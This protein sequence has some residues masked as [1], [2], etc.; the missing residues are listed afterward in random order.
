MKE[1]AKQI[2]VSPATVSLALQEDSRVALKTRERVKELAEKLNY[3]PNR[4]G[5]S[6][7]I[8]RS[9]T[10]GCFISSVTDSFYGEIVDGIGEIASDNGYGLLM[11]MT[12]TPGEISAQ[13]ARFF[14]EKQVDG[15]IVAGHYSKSS[16]ILLDFEEAGIPVVMCSDRSFSDVIPFVITDDYKGGA[17]IA[18]YLLGLGHKRLAYC[19]GVSE[20]DLRYSGAKY[21]MERYRQEVPDFCKTEED[22]IELM[23]S[24]KAP[25]GII[26]YSDDHA[27]KVKNILETM[28]LQIPNDISITGYNDVWLA[29]LKEFSF[30]TMAQE[31]KYI[32][33]RSTELLLDRIEGKEVK[34]E[35]LEPRLVIRNSTAPPRENI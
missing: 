12:K 17:I 19:F 8:Q 11:V 30:T 33:K 35:Y 20:N 23:N 18:E 16:Q 15:I 13:Q 3:I 26:C 5:Q 7:R 32:G 2:G 24:S 6:L 9:Y 25:T 1:L 4:I 27:I 28:S 34:S 10:I 14:K 22:L 31:R 29:G 21:T